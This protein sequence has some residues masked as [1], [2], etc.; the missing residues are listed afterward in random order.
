MKLD[1]KSNTQSWELEVTCKN[2]K[3]LDEVVMAILKYGMID[4]E[5]E[6]V[7]CIT[8]AGGVNEDEWDGRYTVLMWCSWFKI[9]KDIANDLA[10]IELKS[11]SIF[12]NKIVNC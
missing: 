9:L 3:Y 5:V 2:K 1:D 12:L 10:E 6:N 4:F 7:E 11:M 8:N